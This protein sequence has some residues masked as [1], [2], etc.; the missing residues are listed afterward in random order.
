MSGQVSRGSAGEYQ[1]DEHPWDSP[2]KNTGVGRHS[3]L[4]G[5][6]RTQGSNLGL[7][8]CRQIV[9]PSEPPGKPI[10]DIKTCLFNVV[11]ANINHYF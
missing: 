4:Q 7:L 11:M 5:T 9:L 6:F 2:G 10:L 3:P 1:A 8:R